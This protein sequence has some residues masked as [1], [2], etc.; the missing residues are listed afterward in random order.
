MRNSCRNH[1]LS[2]SSAGTTESKELGTAAV[3]PLELRSHPAE[4]LEM[5]LIGG[6]QPLNRTGVADTSQD[7]TAGI[8]LDVDWCIDR[9]VERIAQDRGSDGEHEPDQQ[10]GSEDIAFA[11]S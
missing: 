10:R 1:F 4:L 11:N 3:F 8:T 6:N 2:R 9:V 7:I 5:L